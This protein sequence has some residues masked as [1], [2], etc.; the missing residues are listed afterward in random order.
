M[1]PSVSLTLT[2]Q[3]LNG[4]TLQPLVQPLWIS[5]R[6][7]VRGLI[8]RGRWERKQI[9]RDMGKSKGK[10]SDRAVPI[11]AYLLLTMAPAWSWGHREGSDSHTGCVLCSMNVLS[12]RAHREDRRRKK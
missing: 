3:F 1:F 9:W 6:K 4:N 7:A 8:E 2:P 5:V 10:A 11:G 12:V